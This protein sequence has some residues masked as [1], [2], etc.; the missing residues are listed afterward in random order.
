MGLQGVAPAR[1]VRKVRGMPHLYTTAKAARLANV[2]VAT[3]QK[4]RQQ[5]IV[6]PPKAS[7]GTNLYSD[8]DV[9][10][11]RAKAEAWRNRPRPKGKT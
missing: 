4:Y 3:V 2:A 8:E 1:S 9:V 10:V 7:D 5:G 11:I 6:S